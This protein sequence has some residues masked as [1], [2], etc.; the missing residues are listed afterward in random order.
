MNMNS[1]SKAIVQYCSVLDKNIVLEETT[2]YNGKRSLKCLNSD[3]CKG[4][5]NKILRDR[6]DCEMTD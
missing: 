5:K 1:H 3:Y 2:Y 6:L 4:C